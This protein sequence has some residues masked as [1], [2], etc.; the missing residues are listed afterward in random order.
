[1]VENG[2]FAALEK[3]VPPFRSQLLSLSLCVRRPLPNPVITEAT[4][5]QSERGKEE[6][7]GERG[8][9]ERE[10]EMLL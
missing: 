10:R 9:R 7:T 5:E 8:E 2:S 3:W 1:M 4:T 6:R